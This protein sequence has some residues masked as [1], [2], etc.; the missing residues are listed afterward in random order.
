MNMNMIKEEIKEI[1]D[2]SGYSDEEAF[3]GPKQPELT[4]EQRRIKEFEEQEIKEKMLAK[5]AQLK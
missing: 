1:D 3:A 5:M 2:E 4:D